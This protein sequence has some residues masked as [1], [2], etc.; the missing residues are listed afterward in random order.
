MKLLSRKALETVDYFKQGR[1]DFADYLIREDA[2]RAGC[3]AIA[4]FDRVLLVEN[5]F[6]ESG[7]A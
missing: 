5:D 2:L 1:G 6:F 4:T 7:M 3:K